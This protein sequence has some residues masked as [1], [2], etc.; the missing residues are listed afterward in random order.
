MK[1]PTV[2]ISLGGSLIVKDKLDLAFLKSFRELVTSFLFKYRFIIVCGG[3]KLCRTY[4]TAARLLNVREDRELDRLGVKITELNAE[5]VRS[6]FSEAAHKEVVQNYF[7]K[8]RFAEVLVGAG[9]QPGHSTDY[10]AVMFARRYHAKM[11]INLTDVPYIFDDDPKKHPDAKP[12][13][14]V[15][16]KQYL[17]IV[18]RIFKPGMNAPFD[19]EAAKVI[20]PKLKVCVLKPLAEAEKLLN[21]Q[22]FSGSVLQ[23]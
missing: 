5:L 9:W 10:G 14:T 21:G 1:K 8:V 17:N 4:Q 22:D 7:K 19:P 20:P 6:I 16:V 11:L 12:L 18:G 13:E 23:H 15:K 2:V 3:G